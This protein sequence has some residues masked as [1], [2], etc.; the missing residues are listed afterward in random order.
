MQEDC[1]L[2]SRDKV[3]KF[4]LATDDANIDFNISGIPDEA[5]KRSQNFHIL[6][7]IR[8]ITS[9]PQ[10]DAVQNDLEQQQSFNAF[11]H[12]SKVA[13]MDAGNIEICEIVN[14][15]PKWQCKVCLHH[16]STGVIYCVCGRLMTK[17]SA[18][19][20]KYISATLDTFSIPNF[21]IRKNR[22]HGHRYGKS[23]GCKVYFTANQLAKKF[24]KKE[25]R[26]HP[27]QIHP[28]Q[29]FQE[30]ND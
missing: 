1:H 27:R 13:I 18:E 24:R 23:Q 11:S 4:D 28:R 26:Q 22:P 10:Q 9:H 20:R 6:Q 29:N 17:D 8:R 30:V 14:V 12:G 25:V 2:R 16:C 7:L 5:V 15:E 19:N 21:Y 3:D